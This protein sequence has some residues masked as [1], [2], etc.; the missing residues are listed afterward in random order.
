MHV[1]P[2][3]VLITQK[4]WY[5]DTAR[6][7]LES[8]RV[9][10]FPHHS[11]QRSSRAGRLCVFLPASCG[12]HRQ[13][14]LHLIL[15]RLRK[16]FVLLHCLQRNLHGYKADFPLSVSGRKTN[17]VC[18]PLP[19]FLMGIDTFV[20]QCPLAEAVKCAAYL[21]FSPFRFIHDIHLLSQPRKRV[22]FPL[23]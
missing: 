3:S 15:Y 11:Y 23:S 18:L 1:P 14:S 13:S 4:S 21:P 16:R 12:S 8:D 6:Y 22:E 2:N 20:F 7:F 5:A 10:Q 17:F 19:K 9:L